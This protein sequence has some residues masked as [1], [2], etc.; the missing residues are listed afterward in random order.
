MVD[1]GTFYFTL[2]HQSSPQVLYHVH[3]MPHRGK[4]MMEA[5][6]SDGACHL[7]TCQMRISDYWLKNNNSFK[8]MG[9]KI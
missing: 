3:I 4:L 5:Q 1:M 7:G 6:Y 2:D 8:K 9:I